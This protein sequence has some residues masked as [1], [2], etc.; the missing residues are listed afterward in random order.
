MDLERRV[1]AH[2][3]RGDL[4]SSIL[5]AL[6]RAGTDTARLRTRDLEPIDEFHIGGA[7][8]TAELARR[9]DLAAHHRVLD[10]GSGLGGP[11]RHV[12]ERYGCTVDG[13]DL[14]EAYCECAEELARRTGLAEAVRYRQGSALSMPFPDGAF[15]R[16]LTQHVAMNI[17]DK[18][19]LYGELRRVL[20]PRG[21]LGI[22]DLLAGPGGG[23]HFPVP[24]ARD[25]SE[26]FLATPEEMEALLDD[27]GF[28]IVAWRDRSED[29]LQWFQRLRERGATDGPPPIGFSLL[30]GDGFREMAA[31]QVRNLAERRILP[32]EIVARAKARL[33]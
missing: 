7:E 12:A 2:Y 24:W 15:D 13:L 20:R 25:P 6:A 26:S 11:S 4:V 21:L 30:L 14:T 5:D 9:L 16:A 18:T 10:V 28:E 31:N 1:A 32:T 27:A 33:S 8:A 29:G 3:G 17:E 23:V 19:T 22:Y